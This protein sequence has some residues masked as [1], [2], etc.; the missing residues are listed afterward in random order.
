[1]DIETQQH[2]ILISGRWYHSKN[3]K[4]GDWEFSEPSDLPTDFAN[5]PANS[6]VADVRASIPNTEEAQDALLEQSIPQT[7]KVNRNEAEVSVTYDGEPKFE[8]I[9]GTSM[10]YAVNTDKTVL[11]I[12][13]KYYC[14]DDAIWFVS[15][16]AGGPWEVSI[17]RPDEVDE[18]P[19]E[20]PVYNVKYVYIYESTPEIVYV[21]YYP[22]YMSSYVY[23]GIVVYGTGYHYPYWY[24]HYYYP[25][26]V[27]YGFGVHYNPYSGWGFSFRVSVGW[28]F[29]PHSCWGPRGFHHGYNRGYNNGYRRGYAH[30]YKN[31]QNNGSRSGV[32]GRNRTNIYADANKGVKE[33]GNVNRT[34]TANKD[35]ISHSK[36]STKQNNMYTDKQGNV[37]QQKKD[38]SFENKVNSNKTTTNKASAS[39]ANTNKSNNVSRTAPS[40]SNHTNKTSSKS[41]NTRSQSTNQ[42]LNQASQSRSR[43]TQNYNRSTQSR[44]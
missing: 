6:G 19:P 17:V 39:K 27:T 40:S 44:T 4:D 9:E 28:G 34:K 36:P 15:D 1:M 26:P 23:G 30:G 32:N 24:G 37:Y 41:Q 42:Q 20:S 33:T 18:I 38:G 29:H 3:L 43:G 8:S 25:R 22:G 13:K 21:G 2:Y 14:I 12:D 11:L 31:G 10:S 35:N 5:I 7:A 16:K